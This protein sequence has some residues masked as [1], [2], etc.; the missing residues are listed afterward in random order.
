MSRHGR[1]F[2]YSSP[3]AVLPAGRVALRLEILMYRRRHLREQR[4]LSEHVL[5]KLADVASDEDVE[6]AERR[7]RFLASCFAELNQTEQRVVEMS[8]SAESDLSQVA[9]QL[10]MQLASLYNALSRI[11][12]KLFQCIQ[13]KLR[14]EMKP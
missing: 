6:A 4:R 9:Q 10:N 8:Y 12:R 5:L 14:T 11:R 2:L 7:H 3:A 1:S 13:G